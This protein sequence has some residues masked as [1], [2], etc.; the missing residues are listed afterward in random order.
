MSWQTEQA[1]RRWQERAAPGTSLSDPTDD[2]AR[3]GPPRL[4]MAVAEK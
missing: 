3:N 1:P 2:S 4:L